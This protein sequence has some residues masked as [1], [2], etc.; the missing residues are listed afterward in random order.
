[1][2]RIETGENLPEIYAYETPGI[3]YHEGWIKVGDTKNEF[4]TRI[5]QQTNTAGVS[6]KKYRLGYALYEDGSGRK[7]RDHE[8]HQYLRDNGINDQHPGWPGDEWFEIDYETL[9]KMFDTFR[10]EPSRKYRI[11]SIILREEQDTAIKKTVEYNK[12][13]KKGKY[14][15]NAKPR[16]G[17]TISA[18]EFCKRIDAQN[19]LVLTHRPAV[20]NSWYEDF[21]EYLG[22]TDYKFVSNTSDIKNKPEVYSREDFIKMPR[23][24]KCFE[25]ISLQDLKDSDLFGGKHVK[26]HELYNFHWDLLILDEA[27]E[28]VDTIR[29]SFAL[30]KIIRDFTLHLSGTPF[31]DIRNENFDSD[32][33]F[34]WTYVDEQKA[35]NEWSGNGENPYEELPKLNM[36][37]YRMSNLIKDIK[38]V[39]LNSED[40]EIGYKLNRFFEVDK[41]GNFI[42]EYYVNSFLTALMTD[43]K[44]PFSSEANRQALAHS[45]WLM[46][47]ISAANALADILHK[48]P[49]Y[50]DYEIINVA[51]NYNSNNIDEYKIYQDEKS[52]YDK[53]KKAVEN[54]PR[55]ITLTVKRLTTGVTIPEWTCVFILSEVKSPTDYMQASFRAQNPG[56]LKINGKYAQ[57]T[58]SYVFDF[59]P[60]RSLSILDQFAND[61][62]SNTVNGGG[63]KEEHIHNITQL[64]KYFPVVGEDENG[65]F[66]DL[67]PEQ[68]YNI[69]TTIRSEEVV[70]CG[71]MCSY[72][73]TDD[74]SGIFRSNKVVSKII[75]KMNV[76]KLNRLVS[77]DDDTKEKMHLN[78]E[79]KIEF[80]EEELKENANTKVGTSEEV[81][82]EVSKNVAN[83]D[84]F[85]PIETPEENKTKRTQK[86][87]EEVSKETINIVTKFLGEQGVKL[88]PVQSKEFS[89]RIKNKTAEIYTT[90]DYETNSKKASIL[91]KFR[92]E[93][94]DYTETEI[95]SICEPKLKQIEIE[96]EKQK[97]EAV[98]EIA[99]YARVEATEII[100]SSEA[101]E[102]KKEQEDIIEEHLKGFARTIPSFLMAYGNNTTTLKTFEKD[103]PDQVFLDLTSITKEEFKF[104][105]DG[106]SYID[107]DTGLTMEFEGNVFAEAVFDNAV[108]GFLELK[109]EL[110]D[111]FSDIDDKDIFDY[112]PPQK[113][114]QIFTP[115]KTVK[116]M[117]DFLEENDP[118]CFNDPE[119]TFIDPYMKSGLYITEI[120]TRLYNSKKIKEVYPDDE[121]RLRHILEKQVYGLAPTEILHKITTNFIFGFDKENK[122]E[123]AKK[124]FQLLD[125]NEY[126]GGKLEKKL[127]EIFKD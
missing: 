79:G 102:I 18:M 24:T 44:F 89:K 88:K 73:F 85:K 110:S 36:F 23:G 114:N 10:R 20:A 125:A 116:M 90:I 50:K 6:T 119:K 121:E 3:S 69:P 65:N 109:D 111:Y 27:H 87:I 68:V 52:A 16:F 124:H 67:T 48:H 13:N 112:I 33:I 76:S 103:I 25:F 42:H 2:A 98:N 1:M 58:N 57:K 8:F 80:T 30:N 9:Q 38:K 63:T 120:I 15:W 4:K 28:G 43:E 99:E 60:E 55:T 92:D 115:K 94:K 72:L 117:V 101:A 78:D 34:N 126:V 91:D 127:D 56:V 122:Y 32:A 66:N 29:T 64:L 54:Y 62:Y 95:Q 14:L 105:R 81:S 71:F 26:L 35:K 118:D 47:S 83:L 107:E 77:L 123:K 17:K 21:I 7:F 100:D 5:D 51:G 74:F 70:R 22:D 19:V 108:K 11:Q 61:L 37:T 39:N 12:Q 104:L 75:N 97:Q 53:V 106:G 82:T 93:H 59:N 86:Q 84:I 113:T 96:G 40:L 31:R 41:Q 45:F 49:L 46:P